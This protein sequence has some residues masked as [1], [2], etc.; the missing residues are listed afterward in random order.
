VDGFAI[1]AATAVAKQQSKLTFGVY[2]SF[3]RFAG[4]ATIPQREWQ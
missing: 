3:E 1:K 4:T 2:K